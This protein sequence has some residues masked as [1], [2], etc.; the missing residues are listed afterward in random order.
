MKKIIK[1]KNDIFSLHPE[2]KLYCDFERNESENIDVY[3]LTRFSHV[4]VY[5]KCKNCKTKFS[6]SLSKVKEEILCNSCSLKKGISKKYL[7]RIDKE[8]SLAVK[9]PELAKEWHP[10]KNGKLTPEELTYASNKKVW[11]ICPNG[12]E[13][14]KNVVGRTVANRGCPYCT[15]QKVLKG[16]NDLETIFPNFL[17]EWNYKRNTVL[18]NQVIARSGKKYWWICE[19]GHEW[20]VSPLDRTYGRGCPICSSERKVSIGEKT[21]LYYIMKNYNGKIIPNY[22][23][24]LIDNKELDIYLPELKIGIEYDGV[25]FHKNRARDLLKD[26]ICKSKGI[27]VFHVAECRDKNNIKGNYIYFNVNRESN[28]E[29]ALKE[30]FNI[31]FK[32]NNKYDVNI[33]RDRINIYNLLDYSIKE[34]SLAKNYPELAKEWHPS[35]NGKLKPELVSYGSDKKVWW[36]CIKGHEWEAVISSRV[37]DVGCPFCSGNK[38]IKGENDLLTLYPS[39]AAE[40]HP[41]RNGKL[42]PDDVAI[43]SN[44]KVWWLAKCGHEWETSVILRINGNNCPYCGSQKLL[45]GFNDLKTKNPELAKEWHPSKNGELKPE[46]VISGSHKKAWWLGKC[47]HEWEAIIGDRTRSG[48]GCPFCSNNKL[49]VG[50]N[51]LKTKN[52]ELVKEWHPSKNGELKPENFFPNSHVKVWWICSRGHEYESYINHRN[53]GTGCPICNCKLIIKGIND[54]E[55]LNPNLARYWDNKKNKEKPSEVS[56]KSGKRVWWL[57][58]NCKKSWNGRIA[59]V[60]KKKYICS[61]CANHKK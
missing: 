34:Q 12:H 48:N 16:Y 55:T 21:I 50:F 9:Y 36:L 41:T 30:L 18:P 25:Y 20:Q 47:G 29:W 57:C 33:S 4:K 56:I 3:S 22:R 31:I 23:S 51:D 1:G 13:Y 37:S 58:P 6:R 27:K 8:G 46:N 7:S 17:K 15:N 11:W 42:K 44:K 38:V 14:E 49:L 40:W 19:L 60:A 59:D 5:W 53:N 35:K 54:L 26:N 32:K 28:F 2:W 61:V 24:E 52:P 39:I 43:K 45:K 10:T